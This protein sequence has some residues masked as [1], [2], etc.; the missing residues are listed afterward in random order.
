LKP[1]IKTK[2]TRSPITIF[3]QNWRV[4]SFLTL[5]F[6]ATIL[7]GCK[8]DE[9][10]IGFQKEVPRL[11]TFYHEFTLPATTILADSV[12]TDNIRI[13][14][15]Q[16]TTVDLD[17]L[18]L[19]NVNDPVFGEINATPYFQFLPPSTGAKIKLSNPT[20]DKIT[21]T[22]LFDYYFYGD[23]TIEA[24]QNIK[25]YE[26]QSPGLNRDNKYFNFSQVSIADNP[27]GE[28]TWTFNPDSV[29][30]SIVNNADGNTTNDR[31]DSLYFELDPAFGEKLF[32]TLVQT[33]DTLF[34]ADINRFQQ[35]FNGFALVPAQSNIVMGFNPSKVRTR[36]T[37]YFSYVDKDGNTRHARYNMSLANPLCAGFTKIETNRNTSI[38]SGLTQP[39]TE[40]STGDSYTYLQAGSGVFT[41]LDLSPVYNY[42]DTIAGP[43][44]N[45]AEIYIPALSTAERNHFG[46]PK[47]LYYVL[48]ENNNKFHRAFTTVAL[49]D[50][51]SA[52][53]T[54]DAAQTKYYVEFGE[55]FSIHARGDDTNGLKIPLT[56]DASGTYYKAY[57]T[58]FFQYQLKLPSKNIT[59]FNYAALI[60]SDA[61]QGK[62]LNGITLKGDQIKL[63]VYYSK[64]LIK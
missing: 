42:F 62:S 43:M 56:D 23:T 53:S 21:L 8:D 1:S 19:G 35:S 29:R 47:S 4:K 33:K 57:M 5:C 40:F 45:S 17:R 61:P 25:V 59:R 3:I 44:L 30:K 11:G 58:E 22:L 52:P 37:I 38:L 12:R 54:D 39:Y 28:T 14:L 55:N 24:D 10:L 31:V 27:I 63:R 46:K 49:T 15:N 7:F 50:S 2:I 20:F 13:Y 6:T 9:A 60:P 34:L 48:A 26:V 64:A 41:R 51:T 18:M 32:D 36:L 16:A